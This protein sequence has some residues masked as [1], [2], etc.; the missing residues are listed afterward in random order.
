MAWGLLPT[1]FAVKPLEA[2]Q[3]DLLA[4]QRA[5]IDPT[6]DGSAEAVLGQ[7]NGIYGS[8][9]AEVW[10]L[11][12][13][14]HAARDPDRA[15]FDAL[16]GTGALSATRRKA[17]KK[18]AVSA[19]AT[20][21]AGMT[22][23]AGAIAFVQ[24][25]PTNRWVLLAPI[26]NPGGAPAPIAGTWEAE[27]TGPIAA[28]AG[29][30]TGIATPVFGWTAVSNP[31]DAIPGTNVETDSEYRARRASELATGG[32]APL[33]A[34]RAD[35]A[36]VAGVL[37]VAVFAN[38]TDFADSA[39]RPPH[40]VEAMVLGGTDQ[41]VAD[42]LW[43]SKGAGIQTHGGVT[44][45]VLDSQG[46][47]RA[48]KHSRPTLRDV[49]VAIELKRDPSAYAGNL[50]VQTAVQAWHDANLRMGSQVTLARVITLTQQVAG[51]TDVVSVK[52]GFASGDVHALNLEVGARDLA[53][54]DTAR[55]TVAVLG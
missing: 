6:L 7:L 49:W 44:T 34:I 55:I 15:T 35:I 40:S 38:D 19:N 37:Q 26:T 17:A 42:Q 20:L 16:D 22:L 52:L 32:T 43:K 12:G 9:L 13:A 18:G 29:T 53:D 24:G 21:A 47:N 51:V 3:E 27:Q 14:V 45:T 5:N 11:L 10:E 41:A 50:A 30:L 2:I 23:A 48:V 36:R 28:P 4:A 39:G 8:G 1:G 31:L 54:L 33:D 46:I 25:Q